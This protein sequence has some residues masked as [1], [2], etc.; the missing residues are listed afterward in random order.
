MCGVDNVTIMHPLFTVLEVPAD[1]GRGVPVP[2]RVLQALDQG[3]EVL[4]GLEHRRA[5]VQHGHV[6]VL[7]VLCGT[8]TLVMSLMS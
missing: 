2:E 5:L 7:V 4:Q 3:A 6:H 1:P 8:H